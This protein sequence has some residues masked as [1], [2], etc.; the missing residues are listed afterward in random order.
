MENDEEVVRTSLR[1]YDILEV[2][3]LVGVVPRSSTCF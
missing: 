3:P 1:L 2:C